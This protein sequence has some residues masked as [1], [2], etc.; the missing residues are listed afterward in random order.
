MGLL[1]SL[2]G[3]ASKSNNASIF[4]K[5]EYLFSSREVIEASYK[6]VRDILI[7]TNYRF[8]FIDIK[9]ATGKKVEYFSAPYRN[10]TAFS[11][12]SSGLFDLDAELKIWVNG[13]TEPISKKFN[14][15]SNV[16]E[17]QAILA[18]AIANLDNLG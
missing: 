17:V 15:D 9:G 13:F 12:E 5:Y 1:S 8:I 6:L 14:K 4:K 10:V 11:V 7:F 3:N 18:A 2:F 16:Y